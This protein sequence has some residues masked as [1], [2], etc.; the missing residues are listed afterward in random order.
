MS[1]T[2]NRETHPDYV[3][4]QG[5]KFGKLLFAAAIPL[6]LMPMDMADIADSTGLPK[7]AMTGLAVPLAL[8][9]VLA[10]Y[11]YKHRR[12][13]I[14]A[15][16]LV[17]YGM[18]KNRS[19]AWGD[20]AAVTV[21]LREGSGESPSSF[22]LHAQLRA[23]GTLKHTVNFVEA[24][25]LPWFARDIR[26]AVAP[27]RIPFEAKGSRAPLQRLQALDAQEAA[28]RAAQQAGNP[29]GGA[30]FGAPGGPQAG[31]HGAPG[32]PPQGPYGVQ[33]APQPQPY[34][35]PPTAQPG[36]YGAA[37]APHPGQHPGQHSG[38]HSGPGNP[39]GGGR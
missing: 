35:M 32:V 21:K 1:G 34:G 23:G 7:G 33:P 15:Q 31:S 39:F 9:P 36:P 24:E 27:W 26:E 5:E 2:G 29:F 4:W 12:I 14:S 25:M 22:A 18:T 11:V 10:F 28:A 38:Q 30:P 13:A 19:A 17:L 6:L 8:I 20:I 3:L 37:P 16:G